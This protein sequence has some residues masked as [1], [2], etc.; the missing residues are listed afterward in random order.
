MGESRSGCI[1][2]VPMDSPPSPR[3]A[4]LWPRAAYVHV[5]FCAHHC[6]YC[7]FAVAVGQDTRMGDYLRALR[8]E[9]A[10]LGRP[11]PVQTLFLGGGTPTY[12]PHSLLEELLRTVRDWFPLEAG[13]EFSIE[14]NPGDLDAAKVALLAD[15]GVNRVSLGVQSF[16]PALLQVLERRHRPDDVPRSV[17]VIRQR[18][19]NVS[20]DLIFG[21]PGQTPVQWA[22]DLRQALELEPTHLATYG[23]T[24]EK[25]T[26][27]WKQQQ[28][29][30]LQALTEDAEL[31]CYTAAMDDLEA[32][33]FEHYEISNFARPGYR[34]RHNQ[35][36]WANEAYFGAGV[37]AARYVEGVR[38]LN[39]RHFADYFRRA[40]A[41]E[42][43]AFQS[44]CLPPRERALET[45]AIQLRRAEGIDRAAYRAQTEL[46]LDALLGDRI[47]ALAD[48]GLLADRG[49]RV[50]LTRRGKCVADAVVQQL[51]RGTN[52]PRR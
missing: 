36:Y 21:V 41:G 27:L 52:E 13:H 20:L 14:A 12:L 4:W 46:D 2:L 44:E 50:A 24:F 22:A 5:P 47:A 10:G 51:F 23:L 28:A 26:R 38:E 45:A 34:C 6:G 15:H 37:G 48:L 16:D 18:I 31:A 43:T 7:D 1:P 8:R 49:D 33:G 11:Q 9:L 19:P 42:P 32:A 3:P 35:V 29:G 30:Q 40:L 39:T 17:S 25:G